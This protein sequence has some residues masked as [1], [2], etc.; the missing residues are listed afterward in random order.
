M[1]FLFPWVLRIV[2]LEQSLFGWGNLY[3]FHLAQDDGP[4]VEHQIELVSQVRRN[5][6]FDIDEFVVRALLKEL[7]FHLCLVLVLF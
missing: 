7:L 1:S 6:I 4:L 2:H 3:D 5:E